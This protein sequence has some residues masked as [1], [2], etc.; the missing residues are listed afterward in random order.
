MSNFFGQI[1]IT[2]NDINRGCG[3]DYL[4][5][6]SVAKSRNSQA[7]IAGARSVLA[8]G[9]GY[10][11]IDPCKIYSRMKY[12]TSP[13]IAAITDYSLTG[14]GCSGTW[15]INVQQSME[16]SYTKTITYV[17]DGQCGEDVSV[18]GT[19]TVVETY[20]PAEIDPQDG[21]TI[22]IVSNRTVNGSIISTSQ[23]INGPQTT[24]YTINPGDGTWVGGVMPG[25]VTINE[26]FNPP[27]VD[28]YVTFHNEVTPTSVLCCED[29]YPNYD[30]KPTGLSPCQEVNVSTAYNF[31]IENYFKSNRQFKFKLVHT[32]S[33]TCYLKVWMR[34][35]IK[36]YQYSESGDG[37]NIFTNIFGLSNNFTVGNSEN[38]F[39][40]WTSD[41]NN[42][43]ITYEDIGT[44][45]WDKR[46]GNC[47][48]PYVYEYSK[49]VVP[50]ITGSTEYEIIANS[51]TVVTLDW[52]HSLHEDYTPSWINY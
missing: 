34:K 12:Y 3:I 24:S 13:G 6:T 1:L 17:G 43:I 44:Y 39:P 19:L 50:K 31:D 36:H 41:P 51:G 38:C 26:V 4:D 2:A 7:A 20:T 22:N 5:K 15:G 10:V 14:N 9:A 18:N 29:E 49:E 32:P 11:D 48:P 8:S 35:R 25:C 23:T 30:A 37:K 45:V 33:P 21:S 47:K 46:D 40:E 28:D 42:E 16:G 27:L 52:K